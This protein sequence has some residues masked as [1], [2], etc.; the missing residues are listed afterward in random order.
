MRDPVNGFCTQVVQARAGKICHARI[1]VQLPVPQ[2]V[3]TWPT[4]QLPPSTARDRTVLTRDRPKGRQEVPSVVYA[5]PV[6]CMSAALPSGA[7]PQALVRMAHWCHLPSA[8][9]QSNSHHAATMP[10][11]RL[12]SCMSFLTS[13]DHTTIMHFA[14][15]CCQQL[16]QLVHCS[17]LLAL[18]CHLGHHGAVVSM[19]IGGVAAD[20]CDGQGNH[21]QTGH[22][23]Q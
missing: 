17:K 15:Q 21:D 19:H 2:H 6:A 7:A 11:P 12:H 23:D 5:R 9:P 14:A 13:I 4:S 3:A 10:Q 1:R 8:G 16:S 18:C 22:H 20:D